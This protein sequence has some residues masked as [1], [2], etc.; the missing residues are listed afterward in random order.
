MGKQTPVVFG[1]DLL[2]SRLRKHKLRVLQVASSPIILDITDFYGTLLE[3]L[4][5]Q[6][7]AS[8]VTS[9]NDGIQ[10]DEAQLTGVWRCI[11]TEGYGSLPH[12]VKRT[13]ISFVS[14]FVGL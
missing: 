10:L 2:L 11:I 14:H 3:D 8:Y 6:D 12:N 9:H 4:H 1:N 13:K 7:V 5:Y